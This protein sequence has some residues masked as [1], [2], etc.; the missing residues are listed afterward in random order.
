MGHKPQPGVGK[1]PHFVTQ[2]PLLEAEAK[3]EV[4]VKSLEKQP[5]PKSMAEQAQA[6][7]SA[8]A[9]LGQRGGGERFVVQ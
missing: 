5:W 1:I 3:A 8:L 2:A 9:A 7:R 6:V 4:K